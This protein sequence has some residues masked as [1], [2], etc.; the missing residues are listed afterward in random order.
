MIYIQC[1]E[2]GFPFHDT[3]LQI[4]DECVENDVDYTLLRV[5][6]FGSIEFVPDDIYIGDI[7]HTMR[8]IKTTI[9]RAFEMLPCYPTELREFFGRDIF[10]VSLDQLM[11]QRQPLFVKPK[12]PKLFNGGVQTLEQIWPYLPPG[13]DTSLSS[14]YACKPIDIVSE[15]RCFVHRRRIVGIQHAEGDFRRFPDISEVEYWVS[16]FDAQPVAFCLDVGLLADRQIVV[17]VND[18]LCCC[19]FGFDG[20]VLQLQRDRFSEIR[21]LAAPSHARPRQPTII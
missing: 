4:Y 12:E 11:N 2:D 13:Y 14:C 6:A 8:F 3:A 18:V 7:P 16:R 15:Y 19:T 10:S 20:N 9:N 17:E 21:E 5:D 1:T